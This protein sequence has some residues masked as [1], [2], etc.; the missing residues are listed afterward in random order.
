M[1]QAGRG[2]LDA[3]FG[4][5]PGDSEAPKAAKPSLLDDLFKK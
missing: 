2:A 5:T 4:G 1:A 3:L